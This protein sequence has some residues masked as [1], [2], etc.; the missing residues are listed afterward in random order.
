MV[1]VI[2]QG[3]T[4]GLST[5]LFCLVTCAPAFVPL[6]MA[7]E[8]RWS[9]I[10]RV[11]GELALGRLLAYLAFGAGVGYLGMALQGPLLDKVVAGAMVFLALVMFL[12]VIAR[13]W[14]HLSLCRVVNGRFARFPFLFGLLTGL[15]VC[16]PFL[17]AISSAV[18]LGSI[19]L[20]IALFGGFFLGTSVYL[21]VLLPLGYLGRW[22][23]LRLVALMTAVLA[24][25]FFLVMGVV[26]LVT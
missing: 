24:G 26:R 9:G 22:P 21:L 17:L 19:V 6:L 11:V 4:L 23:N 10:A 18:G 5:G 13:G 1:A 8:R 14:P 2:L 20:G 7:E 12:Y 15:N 3:L 16:P 25:S